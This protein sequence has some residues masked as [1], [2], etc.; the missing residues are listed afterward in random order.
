M[1]AAGIRLFI[2]AGIWV[3][4]YNVT[5]G[6]GRFVM[7]ERTAMGKG[8]ACSGNPPAPPCPYSG[9]TA[10]KYVV[11]GTQTVTVRWMAKTLQLH[12]TPTSTLYE[13]DSVTFTARSSDTRP[14][15]V[16][17]WFWRDS[18][19]TA[20]P[21]PCGNS[22][23]CRWVPPNTGIMYVRA[24]VG[25]NPFF[26]QASAYA[27]L[28]PL[29][30]RVHVVSD[31]TPATAGTVVSF[32]AN[33]V[34]DVRPVRQ[35]SITAAPGLTDAVCTA[36]AFC[37]ALAALSDTVSFSATINGRPKTAKV[38]VGVAP[39][40]TSTT[41]PPPAAC[42]DADRWDVFLA[43]LTAAQRAAVLGLNA[44]DRSFCR[45]DFEACRQ[46]A[47]QGGSY[48][49]PTDSV[50]YEEMVALTD[51]VY[52]E[53]LA[54]SASWAE[55]LVAVRADALATDSPKRASLVTPTPDNVLDLL[56]VLAD[57]GEIV[58]AGPSA[59]LLR[60]LAI[61]VASAFVP[62]VPSPKILALG[63][64]AARVAK[65]N[66]EAFHAAS[67]RGK[68][69]HSSFSKKLWD[70]GHIGAIGLKY[71][72]GR[73]LFADGIEIINRGEGQKFLHIWELKPL[74]NKDSHRIGLRQ[75]VDYKVALQSTEK[76]VVNRGGTMITFNIRDMINRQGFQVVTDLAFY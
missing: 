52:G 10:A 53:L 9:Y 69:V 48:P 22:P 31:S 68:T 30:L 54:M 60:G 44:R 75:L 46:W 11:S 21:V 2:A 25:T 74:S 41:G 76:I 33:A 6:L 28:M 29:E 66:L 5:G 18:T 12:V 56:V 45:Q 35:L 1:A 40:V 32:I 70:E 50:S 23:V 55:P 19:G 17:Q 42:T 72:D 37:D 15:T 16:S 4:F 49:T 36:D 65:R 73:Q 3:F 64:R 63:R 8:V 27:A 51:A 71:P 39:C 62:G 14:V 57:I 24:K 38:F 61:D 34:P 13:G 59:S 58:V 7:F 67:K 47:E 26:E 20:T 43:S